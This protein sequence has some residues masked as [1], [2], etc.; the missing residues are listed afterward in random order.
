MNA[1][2]RVLNRAL[3]LVF[4]FALA[5]VG[6]AAILAATRPRWAEGAVNTV[7]R[8]GQGALSDFASW[9]IQMPGGGNIPIAVPLLLVTAVLLIVLLMVF[10]AT[11]GGGGTATVLRV[12][13]ERGTTEVDRNVAEAMLS[14]R[15][16]ERPDVLSAHTS[17]YLV[18][19]APAIMLT[20]TTREGAHMP[21]VIRAVEGVVTEWDALAGAEIPIVLHLAGR[22]WIDRWRSATRVR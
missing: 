17:V 1:T 5:A 19:R 22:S 6:V 13:A 16:R 4:G 15:M 3:L 8:W 11:R 20:V 14:A 2:N 7:E 18:K 12:G 21:R 9:T 10:L